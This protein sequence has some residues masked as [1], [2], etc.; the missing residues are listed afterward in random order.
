VA[1]PVRAIRRST[2]VSSTPYPDDRRRAR[3]EVRWPVSTRENAQELQELCARSIEFVAVPAMA[4]SIQATLPEAIR[5]ALREAEGFAGCAVMVSDQEARLVTVV[6]FWRG[7]DR[8]RQ[9]SANEMWVDQLL[10]PYID[11][12]LRTHKL[13]AQIALQPETPSS[14]TEGMEMAVRA[15]EPSEPAPELKQTQVRKGFR[16]AATEERGRGTNGQTF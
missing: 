12:Q 5:E 8:A 4:E 3:T 13:R 2:I 7:Q 16:V 6:T 9:A 11:R 14:A 10:D 15:A 1:T